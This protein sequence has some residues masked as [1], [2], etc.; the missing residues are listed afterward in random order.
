M[1]TE[2]YYLNIRAKKII[3]FTEQQLRQQ[4]SPSLAAELIAFKNDKPRLNESENGLSYVG[5]IMIILAVIL[6]FIFG[7]YLGKCSFNNPFS[8]LL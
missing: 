1:L 8:S 2:I 6:S 3:A 5:A 4:V 7:N